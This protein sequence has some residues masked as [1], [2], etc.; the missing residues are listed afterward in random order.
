MSVFKPSVPISIQIR[1][2]IF[3]KYNDP[4]LRFTNDEIFEIIKNNGDVDKSWTIDDM[5]KY[6][7]DICDSGL[8]RNI[9]QNFNTVCFKLSWWPTNENCSRTRYHLVIMFYSLMSNIIYDI[10][11]V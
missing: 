6:F 7:Q 9:A 2:V 3:D 10:F 4:E 11:F 5:E 8:V 1:K